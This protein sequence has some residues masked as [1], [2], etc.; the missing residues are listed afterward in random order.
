MTTDKL[1]L[2][3]AAEL[4]ARYDPEM[5][6]RP[7]VQPAKLVTGALLLAMSLW[8]IYIAGTGMPQ[9]HW[10]AAMH[11]AFVLSTCFLVYGA[12]K[13]HHDDMPPSRW[14]AP[15]GVPLYD[16]AL[17]AIG[18]LAAL[19]IPWTLDDLAFRVGNP[20]NL[21]ILFGTILIF[22]VIEAAR[23][24]MGWPLTVIVLIALA[25]ALYG[26]V[27][28][29]LLAHP[30][31]TWGG[32]ISHIYLLDQ[33]IFG[34]PIQVMATLV[35]H[36]VLFGV[37]ATRMGLGQLFIDIG[38]C[39]A[40]RSPGGPAKVSVISS[41]MMGTISGSSVA[42]TVT[43]GSLTIPAMKKIGYRPH[44]AGAVEAASS[45]GG[46]ITP[47]I[48]G[49]AAFVMAEF[50][51]IPYLDICI[52]AAVPAL[53]H[54]VGVFTIVHFE[55]RRTGLRGLTTEEL[56]RLGK[57]LWEGWPT[58][59]PLV[60][61]V[62]II[63]RGYT[64]YMAA[65]WG[66]LVALAVGV[67][68]PRSKMGWRDIPHTLMEGA[69]YAIAVGAAAAAVGIFVGVITLSG[70]GF[71]VSYAVTQTAAQVAE[72]LLPLFA[73][74]PTDAVTLPDLTLFFT[75]VFVG[76]AC[77]AMGTGIPT[78]A[79]YIILAAIA[80]PAIVLLG[81]PPLAAHLFVLYYGVLADLTPP[82][83]VAA[84]AA[85]GIAGANPFRTG[86]Q[87]FQMGNA[88]V[89][90]PFVFVYSPVML[91]V[92]K[93]GF[94]WIDFVVTTGSCIAGIFFL[95]MAIAGFAFGRLGGLS[96]LLLAVAAVM[97]ISPNVSATMLGIAVAMIPL[98]LNWLAGRRA[99]SGVPA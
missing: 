95:G 80:A 58:V 6:F 54:Y 40:G 35:F 9:T 71:K 44:F 77:V 87:A 84:Y 13:R 29:G 23:R 75:L 17:A 20:T 64:P 48:M 86:V 34:I 39:I 10:L 69:R 51:A 81:V 4:E 96:R 3:A 18:A 30:G 63:F 56:P 90:V 12:T 82:V 14:Y 94:S 50:L 73:F 67:I 91:I 57:V 76:L 92:A 28:P 65:F 47:P 78:T 98:G 2:K 99:G 93:P 22:V 89:L 62:T 7:M 55:A 53:M 16:W 5:H 32:V 49:A 70:L 46:Q 52:A 83:C 97:M 38:Y 68:N 45:T 36:F 15:G 60:V 43:T 79:L 25:Y 1:D 19:Y 72:D 88:K 31:S 26:Y 33:G 41:A 37:I 61:L 66:I 59:I 11:L 85:A 8:H 24:S 21:D 27:V 42:N 74:L